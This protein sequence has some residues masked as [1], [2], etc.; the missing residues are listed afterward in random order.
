M[1]DVL[2]LE[3]LCVQTLEH[4]PDE[5]LIETNGQKPDV[6]SQ[7]ELNPRDNNG[8]K[9]YRLISSI[10]YELNNDIDSY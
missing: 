2:I 10:F 3:I 5:N 7:N 9:T 1:R 4:F 6:I 8:I